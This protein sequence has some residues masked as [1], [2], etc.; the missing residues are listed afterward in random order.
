MFPVRTRPLPRS[1]KGVSSGS[2]RHPWSTPSPYRGRRLRAFTLIE[3]LVVVAIIGILASMLLPSLAGAKERAHVTTCINNLRQMGIALRLYMDDHDSRFP[4]ESVSDL[5]PGTRQPSGAI[6]PV[7]YALGGYSA[8][9]ALADSY[10]L[11]E[12]RPLFSYMAPSPV[13]KCPRDK[14]QP[15][16]PCAS[17]AKQSPSNYETIG[18]SYHYNSGTLTTLSDG[19]FQL[20]RVAGGVAGQ[21]EDWAPNPALYI[22]LHEPPARIYGCSGAGARWYQWH[23]SKGQTEITDPQRAPQEFRSPVAFVDGHVKFHNFSKSIS[24]DPYHPYE[25]TRDWIWYKPAN[26]EVN[27]P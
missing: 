19:G 25:A 2:M 3:L 22:L 10:P 21:S 16:L 5:D 7:Q 9:P 26:P 27:R 6:K 15:I 14:G 17:S 23:M 20:P 12:A 18:C 8:K 1:A 24:T 4:P 11:A 13:Y